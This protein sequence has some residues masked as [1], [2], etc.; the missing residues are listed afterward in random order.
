MTGRSG[1]LRQLS[2]REML[3][4]VALA[5]TRRFVKHVVFM[6]MG[7]PSHN[8][9]N[10]LEAITVLGTAGDL[11]HKSLVFSTV[12]DPRVFERLLANPVKPALAISLHTTNAEKRAQLVPRGPRFEPADLIQLADD[13]APEHLELH[14]DDEPFYTERLS[15][16]GSLFVGEETTVAY[17][18][19]SIGTNHILPT[20]RAARYTGGVWV[21]KFLKTCTYQRMTPAASRRVGAVTERQCEVERMLAHAITAR[22][23]VDRYA[24]TEEEIPIRQGAP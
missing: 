9:T 18:D 10:V 4:Q 19:K 3:A 20:S 22:V 1:L 13:Y 14:V 24:S 23:R 11:A 7:E 6:G 12:G 16:Y 5:R 17:G 8:L 21:G 2:S 15:N